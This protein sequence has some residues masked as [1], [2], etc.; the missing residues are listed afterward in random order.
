MKNRVYK[1]CRRCGFSDIP[2]TLLPHHTFLRGEFCDRC[3][4]QLTDKIREHNRRARK[5][6]AIGDLTA[7]QWLEILDRSLGHCYYCLDYV[8][9]FYLTLDHLVSIARGGATTYNNVVAACHD[10]N[11]SKSI[12]DVN[13]WIE[14]RAI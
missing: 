11:T 6:G 14:R 7:I 2:T 12:N 1:L 10:C 3:Y 13:I 9:I 8:G 5:H 4:T